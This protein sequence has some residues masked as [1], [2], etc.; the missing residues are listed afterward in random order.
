MLSVITLAHNEAIHIARAIRSVSG[1]ASQ[2]FVVDAFSTDGTVEIARAA[3][4]HVV[5]H[6]FV[7]YARQFQWA[8]DNLPIE[9]EWVM[10]LDAD[11]AITP[12]LAAEIERRLPE[13]PDDV[14]GVVLKLG[15][16]FMGR[17]I[18]HGARW[19]RLLR[20]TRRGAARIEQRWMDEHMILLRGRS[21][22]FEQR[23]FD[24]NLKD[25][26][27]FTDK[28]NRYATREALDILIRNHRLLDMEAGP[29]VERA[30]TQMV[31]KRWIKERIYNRAPFWLGPFAYFLY[32]YFARLGF[33]DG[34]EGLIYHFLQGFW[35]RFLVGA[36][37][38]QFEQAFSANDD[39]AARL[40]KLE[41]LSGYSLRGAGSGVGE[42]ASRVR[43]GTDEASTSLVAQAAR[44]TE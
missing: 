39:R 5:Q 41:S 29:S 22:A 13:L 34:R 18:E 10:R 30:S 32:R 15:Y 1:I 43:T 8:L 17:R 19:L 21:V 3:G 6:E 28:H 16:V 4:A 38:V 26:T 14:T 11:E 42:A 23:M 37:V 25:L 9:T 35:Y 31:L 27:F 7:N 12:E 36:K 33:L 40:A 44:A 2:V 24:H 20:I